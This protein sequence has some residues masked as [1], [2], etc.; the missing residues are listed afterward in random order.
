MDIPVCFQSYNAS[1]T[2]SF[3]I[4]LKQY[5][6][7]NALRTNP[8]GAS[9]C[10]KCGKC[11]KHCPQGIEIP[12]ELEKVKRRMENPIYKIARVIAGKI[13]KY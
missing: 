10:I 5:F 4:G 13:G 9:Q 12:K 6:M 7:C 2:D 3:Y 11:Q 1:Y 8:S